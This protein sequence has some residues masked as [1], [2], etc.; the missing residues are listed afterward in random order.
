MNLIGRDVLV[1]IV[2]VFVGLQPVIVLMTAISRLDGSSE[3][4]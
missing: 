3:S 1:S 4:V 2:A